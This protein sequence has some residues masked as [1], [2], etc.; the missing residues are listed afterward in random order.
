[1]RSTL[2][3]MAESAHGAE[4]VSPYLV[5]G[6]TLAFLLFLLFVVVAVGGGR[7]HT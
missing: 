7:D 4:G 5:G 3:T 2:I 6:G 1:M